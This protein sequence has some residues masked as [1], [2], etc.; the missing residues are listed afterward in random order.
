MEE[1]IKQA[2]KI[3]K[4]ECARCTSTQCESECI[5]YKLLGDCIAVNTVPDM[6]EI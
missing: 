5:I 3:I 6:W 2:L 1:K 4:E